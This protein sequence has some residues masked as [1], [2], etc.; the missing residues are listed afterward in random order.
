MKVFLAI[1][2]IGKP[3]AENKGNKD[4]QHLY[5]IQLFNEVKDK[6]ELTENEQDI[7]IALLSD[8]PLG[9]YLQSSIS[10]DEAISLIQKTAASNNLKVD[11]LFKLLTVYYQ[12]DAG[13]YTKDAG[14]YPYLEKLFKYNSENKI[15]DES[16]NRLIFSPH[17]EEKYNDLLVS[18][19]I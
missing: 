9:K 16:K 15:I 6:F 1:H 12:V 3:K 8:D 4:L 13:S 2:D 5:S 18:L 19:G 7:F 17:Y 14:G 11:D 10:L